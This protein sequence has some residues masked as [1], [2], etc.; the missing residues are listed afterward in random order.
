MRCESLYEKVEG[1][2][3]SVA[4]MVA[5]APELIIWP[6]KDTHSI[7]EFYFNTRL[8]LEQI[9]IALLRYYAIQNLHELARLE[10]IYQVPRIN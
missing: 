4:Q 3:R 6:P 2:E 10:V 8:A 7:K 9:V 1:L 5:F